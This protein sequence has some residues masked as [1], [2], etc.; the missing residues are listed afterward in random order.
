MDLFRKKKVIPLPE[1]HSNERVLEFNHV[2][3]CTEM[4]NLSTRLGGFENDIGIAMVEEII[5]LAHNVAIL[6]SARQTD[7][8]QILIHRGRI[9]ALG[10]L[11]GYISRSKVA[12][13]QKESDKMETSRDALRSRRTDH[14]AG[15][16]I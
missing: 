8:K 13:P 1:V 12:K 16:A 2:K 15:L 11:A 10:D 5:N 7:D 3:L 14:Q 4:Q 6:E 9:Q